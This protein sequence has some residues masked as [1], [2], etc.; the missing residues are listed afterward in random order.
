MVQ[1]AQNLEYHTMENVMWSVESTL[2]LF[3][4]IGH[5]YVWRTPAEA[6]MVL[7]IGVWAHYT[8]PANLKEL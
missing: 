5:V 8:S 4:T 2:T 1:G 6:Y 3:P 7:E